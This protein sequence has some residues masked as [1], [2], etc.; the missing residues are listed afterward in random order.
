MNL[1]VPKGRLPGCHQSDELW[2]ACEQSRGKV[3]RF[4]NRTNDEP[5]YCRR[6][7]PFADGQ[8]LSRLVPGSSDDVCKGK[9]G[10][11]LQGASEDCGRDEKKMPCRH[12][13]KKAAEHQ[14]NNHEPKGGVGHSRMR[15][16]GVLETRESL[17]RK[18]HHE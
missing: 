9:H 3:R 17:I 11:D 18:T 15:Q 5:A 10:S 6:R 7:V 12:D 4:V 16:A 13:L 2:S 8:R 1:N 14:A